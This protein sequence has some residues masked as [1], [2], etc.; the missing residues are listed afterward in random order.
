MQQVTSRPYLAQS[1]DSLSRQ[2]VY[3]GSSMLKVPH[4]PLGCSEGTNEVQDCQMP[5][6]QMLLLLLARGNMQ[7]CKYCVA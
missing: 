4:P 1:H 5:L 6:L 2:P 7:L 3:S